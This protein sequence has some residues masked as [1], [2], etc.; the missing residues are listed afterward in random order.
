MDIDFGLAAPSRKV[1]E[2]CFSIAEEFPSVSLFTIG[3]SLSG[4]PIDCMTLGSGDVC[5]LVV[6]A[7]HG[8]EHITALVCVRFLRDCAKSIRDGIFLAGF[9]TKHIFS[10]RKIF[11]IPVINPDGIDIQQGAFPREHVLYPRLISMNPSGRDFTHWQANARGVDLNHNYDAGFAECRV[12]ERKAGIYSGCPTRFGGQYPESEPETQALCNLTRFLSSRLKT[13]VALHTQG[14]EIYYDYLGDCPRGSLMLAECFSRVSGYSVSKPS[15]IA[16]YGGYKDWVI[17]KLGIPAF[18]IECGKGENPLP[19]CD[20]D[21][22]YKKV[23]PILLTA[24]A[25]G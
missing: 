8:S 24:A 13:A 6:G 1:R 18:T 10:R 3:H 16:S 9:D 7:H 20:F 11:V 17:S 23:L 5:H 14:E 19:P 4:Q 21:K 25:F 2:Y 22:I 15:G 12:L